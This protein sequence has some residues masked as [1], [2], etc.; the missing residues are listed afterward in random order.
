M[1]GS[2]PRGENNI[3]QR[4]CFKAKSTHHAV[5]QYVCSLQNFKCVPCRDSS[6]QCQQTAAKPHVGDSLVMYQADVSRLPETLPVA[7]SGPVEFILAPVSRLPVMPVTAKLGV[8]TEWG[9]P[10]QR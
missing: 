4:C 8:I 1:K 3:G 5:L 9:A 2:W 10:L 6:A 7:R